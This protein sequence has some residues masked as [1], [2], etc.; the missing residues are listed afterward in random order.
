MAEDVFI[1]IPV[2]PFGEKPKGKFRMDRVG[3][4]QLLF[5]LMRLG[6]IKG[7]GYLEF[8]GINNR[9]LISDGTKGRVLFDSNGSLKISKTGQEVTT[10]SGSNLAFEFDGLT[11]SIKKGGI[12]VNTTGEVYLDLS[13]EH[14]WT[15]SDTWTDDSEMQ[16]ASIV[17]LTDTD[18]TNCNIYLEFTGMV[19]TNGVESHMRLFNVTDGA[20]VADSDIFVTGVGTANI[21]RVRSAALTLA[22]G[23]K[24]YRL[25]GRKINAGAN[26]ANFYMACYFLRQD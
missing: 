2:R 12:E 1:N 5:G 7:G 16:L 11:N 13:T 19:D 6:D 10:A 22:S 18:F 26:N 3:I 24:I 9:I 21:G 20:A 4:G 14:F 8:D 23:T 15:S 17:S 25:E